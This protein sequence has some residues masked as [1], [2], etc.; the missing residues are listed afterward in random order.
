M[1]TQLKITVRKKCCERTLILK[2]VTRTR[3]FFQDCSTVPNNSENDDIFI[4]RIKRPRST[5]PT[6]RKK[7]AFTSLRT[8]LTITQKKLL[9]EG[10][11]YF[12]GNWHL[13]WPY[14][15]AQFLLD[16]ALPNSPPLPAHLKKGERLDVYYI[17]S[18]GY[19]RGETSLCFLAN[20][21]ALS[22]IWQ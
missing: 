1:F 8:Q 21:L 4:K 15:I 17:S 19:E 3:I 20:T 14:S 18:E 16:V 10:K 9:S 22:R 11:I 7:T 2:R 13:I 12:D 6:L 5:P